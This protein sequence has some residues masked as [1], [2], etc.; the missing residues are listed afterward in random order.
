M[1][2]HPLR[3]ANGLFRRATLERDFGLRGGGLS[4]LSWMHSLWTPRA[5]A[6]ALDDRLTLPADELEEIEEQEAETRQAET[7][8]EE[9][10]W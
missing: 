4:V 10:G 2:R 3:Q 9:G 6:R 8:A 1:S 7:E 5:Q